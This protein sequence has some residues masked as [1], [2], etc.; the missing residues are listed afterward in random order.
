MVPRAFVYLS[1]RFVVEQELEIVRHQDSG[2]PFCETA[3]SISKNPQNCA[4]CLGHCQDC[5]YN[6]DHYRKVK[7]DRTLTREKKKATFGSPA[8]MSQEPGLWSVRRPREV[9]TDLIKVFT[10]LS[11]LLTTSNVGARPSVA[12]TS[13][14]EFPHHNPP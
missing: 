5:D 11:L 9:R 14:Q 8:N 3:I 4:H 1:N 12:S 2:V 7:C 6:C 13:T 10:L